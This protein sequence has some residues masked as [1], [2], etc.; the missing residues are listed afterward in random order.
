MKRKAEQPKKGLPGYMGTY[1]DMM[2]LLLTF[3]VLL[4]SMSTVDADKFKALARSMST[5][6][7]VLEGGQ[8][9]KTDTN[10][11]QNGMSQ[12][13]VQE[14]ILS[15]QEA[16]LTQKELEATVEQL[17]TYAK[18]QEIDD[19]VTIEQQGNEIVICF[20]DMLLFDSGK[21]E[22]KAGAI[23]TLSS[24]GD[25]LKRYITQGYAMKVE[26]HTDNVPIHTA[27]FSSNWDLSGARALAVM[28]FYFEEMDFDLSKL[29][30]TGMGEYQ[31]VASNDT[32]EGRAMNRRVEIRLYKKTQG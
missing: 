1:G 2:T 24:I 21:A 14:H 5:S 31:P 18:Q 29:A 20:D 9:M 30:Y 7:S 25:Q 15:L 3:F 28:R 17:K 4:F 13:P 23:P 12:F 19:K 11:L 10:I 8:T 27:Q 16:A 22:L 26:G 32:P 6:I